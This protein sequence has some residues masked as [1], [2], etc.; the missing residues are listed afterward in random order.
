MFFTSDFWRDSGDTVHHSSALSCVQFLVGMIFHPQ[1]Q[2]TLLTKEWGRKKSWQTITTFRENSK[3]LKKLPYA[4]GDDTEA[5]RGHVYISHFWRD[6]GGTVH[7]TSVM[8]CVYF[9]V[10]RIFHPQTQLTFLTKE[11]GLR[12]STK[13]ITTL[14]ENSKVHYAPADD[15]EALSGYVYVYSPFLKKI[16]MYSSSRPA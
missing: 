14:R 8:S 13:P 2:L 3:V 16:R 6:S 4:P 5:L 9:L 11:W 7:H 12:K 1:T 10:G 15:T